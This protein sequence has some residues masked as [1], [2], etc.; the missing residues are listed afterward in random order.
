MSRG[1]GSAGLA[2]VQAEVVTCTRAVELLFASGAVRANGAT[3]P[4]VINGN[5]YAG[6]GLLGGISQIEEVAD[7]QSAG[8]RLT[9][10]G[11]PRDVVALALAEPYQGRPATV[12]EVF[13][14]GATG[15]VVD[16]VIVFRGRMD[17]MNVRLGEAATIEVTLE[18]RLTDMDRPN[19][20]RFTDEDQQRTYPGDRG[21]EFVP[22]TV[23]REIIWPARSFKE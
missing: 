10:A 13:L 11:I 12:W 8:L 14:D 5:T 9:L 20:R 22:A 4:L 2:A 21:F 3:V 7:L 19:L 1:L 6:L 17:Q 23:E 18:D 16:A 15:Q